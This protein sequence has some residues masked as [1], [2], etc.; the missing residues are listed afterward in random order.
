MRPSVQAHHPGPGTRGAVGGCRDGAE[1]PPG[2]GLG[3][4]KLGVVKGRAAPCPRRPRGLSHTLWVPTQTGSSHAPELSRVCEARWPGSPLHLTPHGRA[5][6]WPPQLPR[7]LPASPWAPV[8]T[9]TMLGQRPHLR[10]LPGRGGHGGRRGPREDGVQGAR[11]LHDRG[12]SLGQ[13][14]GARDTHQ[15]PPAGPRPRFLPPEAAVS[16][17]RIARPLALPETIYWIPRSGF[18][19]LSRFGGWSGGRAAPPL[20]VF[21]SGT[22]S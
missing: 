5:P 17:R 15:E 3:N 18:F 20:G 4:T 11:V 19:P 12:S 6:C 2:Q 21:V 9:D 14:G 10:G 16:H 8:S 13:G 22:D 1:I 7:P